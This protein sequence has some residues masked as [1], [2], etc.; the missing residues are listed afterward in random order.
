MSKE[1][2]PQKIIYSGV[3]PTGKLHI[4]NYFGALRNFVSL[5]TQ[6]PCYFSIADLHSLTA[7]FDPKE[8][9]NQVLSLAMDY[10]AIGLD[11]KRCTIFVQSQVPEVAE[12]AWIFNCITPVKELERMTQFKDKALV[13]KQNVNMGLFDYPVLQAADILLFRAN[14]VPVGVDQVQHVE[15]A[16]DTAKRF[17]AAFGETFAHPEALLTESPKIM[18]LTE[19]LK[20]MSK[21][22]G[23]KTYIALTDEPEVIREKIGKAVTEA[24]GV[25]DEKKIDPL[26][27]GDA[28]MRGAW[29]LLEMLKLFGNA[30]EYNRFKKM[31]K[32][33]YKELKEAVA[34]EI[35]E[36]FSLF[37]RHR[38]ELE[39]DPKKVMK[40][41]QAGA[42]R[43][44][45]TA[46][47][48]MDEVR[49][50][51]GIR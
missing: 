35:I 4:G 41:L 18:S 28:G 11:P 50:K 38:K 36:H 8:K 26:D 33:S 19:P 25:I 21:S 42:I 12:L 32:V 27:G 1:K 17:N 37:R 48:T 15:L 31:K 16:R 51:I 40:I 24:T 13:Q 7:D 47:A 6:Y 30:R 39:K 29:N 9:M 46:I 34:D 5:Q 3:Q 2:E 10:L 49:R 14:A 20:K 44:R 45:K 23:E 22:L 43:A